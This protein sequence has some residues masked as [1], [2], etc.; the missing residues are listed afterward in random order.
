M[1]PRR[2]RG[3]PGP[4]DGESRRTA[5]VAVLANAGVLV[6]KAAAAVLTGSAVMLA[7]TFHSLADVLNE[8]LLLLGVSRSQ[9]PA[10]A[11]HPRG[12]G[13]D[14]YF[15]SLLAAV[16][17]LVAGGLAS[18]AEGVR[19]VLDPRPLENVGLG[20]AVLALSAALEGGS[21]VVARRQLRRDAL[22]HE[23]DADELID[24]TTDP[25]PITVYFEDSAA[26]V[27]VAVAIAAMLLHWLTGQ[28]LW[29]AGGS[30]LVG[31]LL[32]WAAARLI[33][34]N[35]RLILVSS[36]SPSVAAHVSSVAAE[37]RWVAAV[38]TVD[39]LVVGPGQVSVEL[40]VVPRTDL[41]VEDVVRE[42]DELRRLLVS[43]EG[44]SS[45]ALTLVPAGFEDGAR[46]KTPGPYDARESP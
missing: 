7:E 28:E 8:L 5:V 9:R 32:T 27:G 3:H 21:W 41:T 20:L 15:W 14:R 16:G 11:L 33:R 45:V 23:V 4:S 40:E 31:L 38:A 39:V 44:V 18:I 12:H 22:L 37:R 25:T 19:A 10:D 42:V 46:G 30:I 2:L 36:A 17:I 34:L 26:I 6:A 35:R 24:V 29:D 13:P 1:S 43:H